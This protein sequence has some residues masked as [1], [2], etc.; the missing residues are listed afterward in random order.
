MA[1]TQHDGTLN[2]RF[3]VQRL[4]YFMIIVCIVL[5]LLY[6]GFA[7]FMPMV[8]GIFFAFMLKPIC[9][10][11]QRGVH[12][13]V[14]AIALTLIT[15]FLILSGL[16]AFFI[17][18]IT[19]VVAEA[20]DVVSNIQLKAYAFLSWAGEL[21][22]LTEGEIYNILNNSLTG[23]TDA[24]LSIVTTGLGASGTMLANFSLMLIYT[25]F[26]L[27][28]ST[29][30]KRF[31]LGQMKGEIKREGEATIREVQT[32]AIDYLGGMLTVML[33]LGVMNSLGLWLI[34]VRFAL[35]WGF[36]GGL[37]AVIPYVGTFIGGL[38][39]FLYSLATTDSLWQPLAVVALYVTIQ[40]LE[41]NFITPKVVGNS[42]KV[43]ALAAVVSLVFGALFWGVAGVI[44]AIPLLAM[45]RVIMQHIDPTKALALLLSDDL[46]G[47]SEDF[48][49][50]Y[51][52]DRHRLRTLFRGN[53]VIHVDDS[54]SLTK[55]PKQIRQPD[56]QIIT[57]PK[58]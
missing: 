41:G 9:D 56:T 11:F 51:N 22:G 1:S 15:V 46:Y 21:I 57:H 47:K 2:A 23:V 52:N 10:R 39:P 28:Y 50:V 5:T 29:A 25:F 8:Y 45:V 33:I 27:L 12:S 14:V 34:G 3:S 17:V 7:F 36:L 19:E 35:V 24:P 40:S 31:F 20:D 26:F 48:L 54:E 55:V 18:E 53:K 6:V 13:R 49:T 44:L 4:A 43:N 37:L 30:L 38:L 42:V 32:V 58:A 16:L